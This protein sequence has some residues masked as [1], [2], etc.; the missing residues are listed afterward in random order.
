VVIPH[1]Y[2]GRGKTFFWIGTEGYIQTSPYTESFAVP[3]ALER[4]GDFSQSY[5][6]DG[7]LNVIYD[8]TKTF[9]D[10]A[11]VVHRT[12]FPNN[13]IPVGQVSTVGKNIASYYPLPETSG[14]PVATTSPAS[15]MCATMRRRSR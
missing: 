7:T 12:P 14:R 9:T 5:N 10:G 1:L 11:G 8:P 6:S 15:T 2:D 3:T 13:Q 4:N